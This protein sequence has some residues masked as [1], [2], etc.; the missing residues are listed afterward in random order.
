VTIE[1]TAP[2]IAI[3]TGA[4]V[5]H[6]TKWLAPIQAACDEYGINTPMRAAAFLAQIGCES[7]HLVYVK[8]IWGPTASQRLYEPPS[9]KA[10]ELG[11]TEVGDGKRFCGRGLI[12]LTGRANYVRVGAA[13]KLDLANHPELLELPVNAAR[14]AG[15]F[16]SENNLNVMADAG[17]ITMISRRVNGGTNGLALRLALYSAAKRA[18]RA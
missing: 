17:Q 8:E 4:T 15:L 11:N 2:I 9:A 6:A 16:W 18:L 10:R 12:E 13:L 3:G 1:L 5:T 7:E 14:S